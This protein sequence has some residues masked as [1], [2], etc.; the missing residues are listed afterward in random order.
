MLTR[1]AY[2]VLQPS[3]TAD[4]RLRRAILLRPCF[5]QDEEKSVVAQVV[6]FDNSWRGKIAK[7]QVEA[8]TRGEPLALRATNL[9]E[10]CPIGVSTAG[11]RP[12]Q[13]HQRTMC[14]YCFVRTVAFRFPSVQQIWA[15]KSLWLAE[16]HYYHFVELPGWRG[17]QELK[18]ELREHTLLHWRQRLPANPLGTIGLLTVEPWPATR[19]LFDPAVAAYKKIRDHKGGRYLFHARFLA[20]YRFNPGSL[21]EP[22]CTFRSYNCDTTSPSALSEIFIRTF[23][24]PAGLAYGPSAGIISCWQAREYKQRMIECSGVCRTRRLPAFLASPMNA[25]RANGVPA[26]P[27][28]PFTAN[29]QLSLWKLFQRAA[30]LKGEAVNGVAVIP[31]ED[32]HAIQEAV[33]N[34]TAALYETS[35]KRD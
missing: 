20:I 7:L 4:A 11:A 24:Y 35:T 19:E 28:E 17:W 16:A 21:Q 15:L 23:T 8:K 9:P 22:G 2:T 27:P 14:P 6:S 26:L 34:V 10:C 29:H 31:V 18:K 13:C 12:Y 5:G 30:K 3:S 25:I 33:E 32:Y 1:A